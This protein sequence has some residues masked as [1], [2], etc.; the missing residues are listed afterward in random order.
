LWGLP[1]IAKDLPDILMKQSNR[2][3]LNKTKQIMLCH[4]LSQSIASR[5][6]SSQN[7]LDLALLQLPTLHGHAAQTAL[8]C[9]YNVTVLTIAARTGQLITEEQQP[10]STDEQQSSMQADLRYQGR[11]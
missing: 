5:K 2:A 1:E 3:H 11:Q 6:H 4:L 10:D 9:P 8:N 7:A